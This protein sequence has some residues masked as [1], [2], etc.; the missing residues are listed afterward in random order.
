MLQDDLFRVKTSC[1]GPIFITSPNEVRLVQ[2][3]HR[4]MTRLYYSALL[5]TAASISHSSSP[6]LESF[7][8]AHH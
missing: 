3:H 8:S 5:R 4:S 2:Y 1:Q 6:T 7:V